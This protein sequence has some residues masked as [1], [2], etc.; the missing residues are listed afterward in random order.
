MTA[1]LLTCCRLS[2]PHCIGLSILLIWPVYQSNN[3]YILFSFHPYSH[4]SNKPWPQSFGEHTNSKV[5]IGIKKKNYGA[6]EHLD[7]DFSST[8]RYRGKVIASQSADFCARQAI[9]SWYSH[10]YF[11]AWRLSLRHMVAAGAYP[12]IIVSGEW[13]VGN[14]GSSRFHSRCD[15]LDEANTKL[16]W[17]LRS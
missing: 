3:M 11:C 14:W 6:M 7:L 12:R 16:L 10:L 2:F 4:R 15:A 17:T 9:T 1:W 13:L 8:V 5:E